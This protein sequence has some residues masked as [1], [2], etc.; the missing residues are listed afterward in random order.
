[1]V[2]DIDLVNPDP[3]IL[4][5]WSDMAKSGNIEI[6][7]ANKQLQMASEDVNIAKSGHL[8]TVNVVGNYQYQG[9]GNVDGG[10]Q[11]LKQAANVPGS[12]VSQF[13]VAG[14]GVQANLP[15][16]QG[17]AVSSQIRQADA[18][19][20][21]MSQKLVAKEREVD[22]NVKN[23]YWKIQNGVSIVKA[24]TQA[25]KSAQVKLKSDETGY[26]VGVR[27][28]VDLVNSEKNYFQALQS[29]NQSRYQYLNARLELKYYAGQINVDF[30]KEINI[31]IDKQKAALA[32]TN[33]L[34]NNLKN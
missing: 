20:V 19:Y 22:Q 17:G 11:S 1:M 26:Q 4:E 6:K 29:Y 13:S 32:I 2:K 5:K 28:S 30:L 3:D 33:Q 8:P 34:K 21:A 18:L 24:Q 16:Y 25:L 15:I 7:I 31:N 27:N 10:S 9:G 12:F 14:V 23:A